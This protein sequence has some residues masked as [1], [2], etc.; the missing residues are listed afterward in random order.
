MEKFLRIHIKNLKSQITNPKNIKTK[1]IQIEHG[2][3]IDKKE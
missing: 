1:Q 2:M 3:P